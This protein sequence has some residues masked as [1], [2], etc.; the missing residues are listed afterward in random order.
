MVLM[1]NLVMLV[2]E[3]LVVKV[4][5]LVIGLKLLYVMLMVN[6]KQVMYHVNLVLEM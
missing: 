2:E 1:V 3:H 5:L 4:E 6:L